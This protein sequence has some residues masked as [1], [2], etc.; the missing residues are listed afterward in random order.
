MKHFWTKKIKK[1][2]SS[3]GFLIDEY[4]G[5]GKEITL[6]NIKSILSDS[7][8]VKYQDFYLKGWSHPIAVVY[9]DGLVNIKVVNDDILKPMSQEKAL[10]DAKSFSDV[11]K[12]IEQGVVYHAS[13]KTT[14]SLGDILNDVLSGSVALVFDSE[15]KAITFDVKGYEKRAITEPTTE[16]AIKG[17]K[18]SFIEVLRVNTTLVRRRIRTPYLRIRELTVGRQTR[19]AVAVVY[20]EGL[21]NEQLVAE[22]C[23]RLNAIDID[24][25]ISAAYIEEYIIDKKSSLFPQIVNTERSDK[26]CIHLIEGRVGIIIDGLPVTYVV[27]AT[28]NMFFEA[29]EDFAFNY[30]LTSFIRLLRYSGALIT[31][32]LP[33]FYI[34]ITTFHHEMIPTVLAISIIRSKMEVPFP[35]V[36]S[37]F[38]MLLAFEILLEAGFRLPRAIGQAISII[39]ALV[40]GQA[41][42]QAKVISPVAVI[43][44][45]VSG[46]TGFIMPNQD[47]AYAIR[48]FRLVLVI[49]ASVAGLY[50]MSLVFFLLIYHMN[51]IET[52]GVP[53]FTPFVANE[54]KQMLEDTLI[55]LP[56]PF[57]K[58]RPFSLRTYNKKRQ[59]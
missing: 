59:E 44:V 11:M 16:S 26:F 19:T 22:V 43:V 32:L 36:T 2:P 47:M 12:L 56:L 33:A 34:A 24:S 29:P 6:Q 13:K 41:A 37:I 23:K 39:G 8:D 9:I 51:T 38:G 50:G 7:G 17:P 55:R 58:K 30:Y 52:F 3:T 45:A 25:V 15:K 28:I 57:L 48:L 53:Y 4:E 27:P 35:T 31:M 42:V 10:S 5:D 40:V 21:T 18:D 14:T 1:S 49:S 20:I 54:G 46:I